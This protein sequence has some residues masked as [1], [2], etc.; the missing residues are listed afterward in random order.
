MFRVATVVILL[1]VG[2]AIVIP[3]LNR[4]HTPTERVG[5]VGSL[6]AGAQGR[7]AATPASVGV[8]LRVT[9]FAT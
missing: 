3:S 9:S 6:D 1:G 2:A 4:A 8:T 7:V 5:V